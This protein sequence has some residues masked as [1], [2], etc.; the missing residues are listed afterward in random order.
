MEA[1][2][3]LN[4]DLE[5]L[6]HLSRQRAM[7]VRMVQTGRFPELQAVLKANKPKKLRLSSDDEDAIEHL[8]PV[9]MDG[10]LLGLRAALEED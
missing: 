9:Y 8:M 1:A 10:I 3:M 6:I 5:E 2:R 4:V 7:R